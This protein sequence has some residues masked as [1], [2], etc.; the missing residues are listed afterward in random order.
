MERSRYSTAIQIQIKN[1]PLNYRP[2]SLFSV[3]CKV[4]ERIVKQVMINH[5]NSNNLIVKQQHGFVR[6]KSCVTNL[7]ETLD[8]LTETLNRGFVAIIIYLDFEKA[9]DKV[10]AEA[11]LL[12]LS[13]YGFN[14]NI[15]A[16]IKSFLENRRQRVCVNQARSSWREVKFKVFV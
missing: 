8:I 9:F 14:G 11:L 3:P 7:L 13:K 10:S 15:L 16:W 1:N 4:T 6:N 12:K 2:I 5:L